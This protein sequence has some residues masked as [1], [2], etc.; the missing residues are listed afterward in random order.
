MPVRRAQRIV[1]RLSRRPTE[2]PFEAEIAFWRE[3]LSGRPPAVS[4]A[5]AWR[6]AF[7]PHLSPL[8]DELTAA[9]GRKVEAL[10]VGSGPVSLLAWGVE[11]G[12]FTLIAV[13]PLA[14]TYE[15]LMHSHGYSYPV[16]PVEGKGEELTNL[17]PARRFDVIY[18]SNA[19]DHAESPA[20]CVAAMTNVLTET[21]ILYLEGFVREGSKSNWYGLHRHDLVPCDGQLVRYGPNGSGTPV[22]EGLALTCIHERVAPFRDRGLEGLGYEWPEPHGSDW[23][24]DPWYTMV[25]TKTS[26]A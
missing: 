15:Q 12:L 3:Y 17:F 26:S 23:R 13:D 6:R 18:S 25:F 7:P 1:R 8:L 11:K 16:A 2:D 10:E 14:E 20:M 19:I 24:D 5:H 21:G 4:D 22:T 9:A